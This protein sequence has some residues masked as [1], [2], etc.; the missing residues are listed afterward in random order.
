MKKRMMHPKLRVRPGK[1]RDIRVIVD[2]IRALAEYERLAR[3]VKATPTYIR[4]DGFGQ[5][6]YFKTLIC[7]ERNKPVG[8][9]TYFFTYST[10]VAQPTLYVEDLFVMP[11]L[12]GKG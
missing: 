3:Q 2:M 1:V 12:R 10:F 8:F 6:P 4:R 11:Q 9:A 5:R 7:E